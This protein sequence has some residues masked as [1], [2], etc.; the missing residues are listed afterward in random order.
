[1]V[2][3]PS[4]VLSSSTN[5]PKEVRD[6]I[7]PGYSWPTLSTIYSAFFKA[8]VSR[9]A[10]TARRSILEAWSVIPA[11]SRPTLAMSF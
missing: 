5:I 8:S 7:W 1:M 10:S 3:K 6:D 2:I 11:R 4:T 9:S